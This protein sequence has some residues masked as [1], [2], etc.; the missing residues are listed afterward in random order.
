MLVAQI[1]V[2]LDRA[3]LSS[4]TSNI[5]RSDGEL[6]LVAQICIYVIIVSKVPLP[7]ARTSR[8]P[9]AAVY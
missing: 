6:R 5:L 3:L 8:A 4:Q 9:G 2:M 7:S 1:V